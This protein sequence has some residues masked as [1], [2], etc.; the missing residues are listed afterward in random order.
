MPSFANKI[1]KRQPSNKTIQHKSTPNSSISE[2]VP[3]NSEDGT[4]FNLNGDI[5]YIVKLKNGGRHT[6][7]RHNKKRRTRKH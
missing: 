5:Y 7:K 1:F 2:T 4:T 3:M 6:R